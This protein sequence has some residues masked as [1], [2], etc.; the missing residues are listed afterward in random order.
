MSL[1]F[2]AATL[3]WHTTVSTDPEVLSL[4][5]EA[6]ADV[7]ARNVDGATALMMA[8]MHGADSVEVINALIKAGA[9]VNA[10]TEEGKTALD[11]ARQVGNENVVKVLEAASK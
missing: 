6:G 11:L 1:R 9:D 2:A 4:L 7:N 3:L 10:K 8:A 5:L